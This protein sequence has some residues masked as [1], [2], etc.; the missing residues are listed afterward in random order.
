MKLEQTSIVNKL[1]SSEVRTEK[2][3]SPVLNEVKTTI[4]HNYIKKEAGEEVY[5]YFHELG[6]FNTK[7]VLILS[8]RHSFSYDEAYL[9]NI[10]TIFNLKQINK[11]PKVNSLF[12][13]INR[14]LPENG[15]Y[16]GCYDDIYIAQKKLESQVSRPF[17]RIL[18]WIIYSLPHVILNLPIIS[19]LSSAIGISYN[20]SLSLKDVQ[21]IMNKNG[22]NVV[23]TKS[24]N[25]RTFFIAKKEAKIK[26]QSAFNFLKVK[27]IIRKS[28]IVN[29]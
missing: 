5:N 9:K 20:R 19:I 22:F 4:Y 15:Y 7:D 8:S 11:L 12:L 23:L 18:L 16:I 29:L 14:I 26:A 25:N 2:I 3:K 17:V 28:L 27:K 6:V 13:K 21:K 10:R 1:P 24:F